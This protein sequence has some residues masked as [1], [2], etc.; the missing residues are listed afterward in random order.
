MITQKEI[1][2][3]DFNRV[4]EINDYEV[5]TEKQVQ[6][7]ISHVKGIIQKSE[8]DNLSEDEVESINTFNEDLPELHKAIVLNDDLSRELVFYRERKVIFDDVIE[9]SEGND[10]EKARTIT[11][12]Y[13]NTSQNR[14]LGRVGKK[15]DPRGKKAEEEDKD[16]TEGKKP[17][18]NA[19][20]WGKT[21]EERNS[22][23]DK[24]EALKTEE[25]KISF[26]KKL[27]EGGEKKESGGINPGDTVYKNGNKLK[28]RTKFVDTDGT[29][30]YN[31]EDEDGNIVSTGVKEE[32]LSK[33]KSGEKKE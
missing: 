22:N 11:G 27:K 20:D 13:A 9:K 14:K 17:E 21:T 24:Y 23:L 32:Q 8:V 18:M 30:K 26:L 3:K 16:K 5:F 29:S 7:Y 31:L 1:A 33:Y 4:C 25:E 2:R 19:L 15:Y 10:I 6:G 12:T 28:V